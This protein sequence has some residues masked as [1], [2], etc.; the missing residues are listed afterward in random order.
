M[1]QYKEK[2]KRNICVAIPSH[3]SE[4]LLEFLS[5]EA[6]TKNSSHRTQHRWIEKSL[7]EK[8]LF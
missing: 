8:E 1:Q 2:R 6:A 4:I 7:H 3:R 5:K